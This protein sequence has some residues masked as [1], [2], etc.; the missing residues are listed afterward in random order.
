MVGGEDALSGLEAVELRHA[1]IHHDDVGVKTRR[2]VDRLQPVA[3]FS[4]DVDVLLAR[5]EHAEAGPNHRLVVG[6]EHPD[7][8]GRSLLTGRRAQRMKPP[9]TAVPAVISPP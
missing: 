8:H 1:D 6:D 2:L 5:E 9:P 3:G 7:R 4:D